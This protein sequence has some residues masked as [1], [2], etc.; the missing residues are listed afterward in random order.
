M[1]QARHIAVGSII[2][3][4]LSIVIF[5]ILTRHLGAAGYGIV[6]AALALATSIYNFSAFWMT[7][8][9]VRSGAKQ[10]FHHAKLGDVYVI[11]GLISFA[12]SVIGLLIIIILEHF[13]IGN[14]QIYGEV[15]LLMILLSGLFLLNLFRIGLQTTQSFRGYGYSLWMDKILYLPAIIVLFF[16]GQLES[17][18]V[19]YANAFSMLLVAILGIVYFAKTHVSLIVKSFRWHEFFKATMPIL[20]ATIASYF[21]SPL[22]VILLVGNLFGVEQAGFVGVAFVLYGFF[23][24]PIQWLTPTFLPKFTVAMECGDK[25][26]L[27]DHVEK[28]VF[29][30]AILYSIGIVAFIT[31]AISTPII[32]YLVGDDFRTAIPV[33]A[34]IMSTVVAETV[35]YLIVSML[36]ARQQETLI[37]VAS[38]TRSLS[39]LLIAVLFSDSSLFIIIGLLVGTWISVAVEI[40][41]LR[42]LVSWKVRF[43]MLVL[44]GLFTIL[45]FFILMTPNEIILGVCALVFVVLGMMA[46]EYRLVFFD[47]VRQIIGQQALVTEK[48]NP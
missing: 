40:W 21:S 20:L 19:L 30:F 37:L 33:I 11:T 45:S 42:D 29:P 27:Q 10:V 35:H 28:L 44:F 38:A 14:I 6:A 3:Q 18:S 16:Y 7:P 12:L 5:M 46:F 31:V 47:Y 43:G 24:Q 36:Y 1:K 48:V 8:Y 23:L 4:L 32:P 39:F 9:M 15:P 41:A 25:A 2:Q 17:E 34:L 22:F 26:R 13:K